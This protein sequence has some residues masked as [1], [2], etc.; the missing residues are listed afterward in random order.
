M[1]TV[2]YPLPSEHDLEL[3]SAYL[4]GELTDRERAEVEQRLIRE[5]ALRAALDDLRQTI[6]LVQSLPALKAPRNFTLN[7]AIYGRKKPWWHFESRLEWAGMLGTAASVVLIVLAVLLSQNSASPKA[8]PQAGED[9]A[10][11]IIT[12]AQPTTLA[13]LLTSAPTSIAFT[14]EQLQATMAMQNAYFGGTETAAAPMIAAA[15]APVETASPVAESALAAGGAGAE[16]PLAAGEP[17]GIGGSSADTA[18]AGDEE[19]SADMTADQAPPGAYDVMPPEAQGLTISS[20]EAAPGVY[21]GEVAMEA[22]AAP[23]PETSAMKQTTESPS[24]IPA[25]G[26]SASTFR[27]AGSTTPTR[28]ADNA[29]QE[30]AA[31]PIMQTST[32]IV[33]DLNSTFSPTLEAQIAQPS[34]VRQ[35]AQSEQGRDLWWLAGLGAVTLVASILVFLA[36]RRKARI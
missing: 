11:A 2:S 9:Q 13:T 27:D 5:H 30:S 19:F 29:I 7:P 35:E 4:D 25:P 3:L 36:G 1:P 12:N 18:N 22:A 16:A 15:A 32:E 21:E 14:G 6:M 33:A 28:E 24:E 17:S 8:E 10:V 20:S 31:A 26:Q 34:A 23:A